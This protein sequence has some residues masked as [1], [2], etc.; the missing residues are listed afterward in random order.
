MHKTVCGVS[1]MANMKEVDLFDPVKDWLEERGYLVYPEVCYGGARADIVATNHPVVTVVE[2][3]TSLSL[4]VIAQAVRWRGT[5]NYVY[6][7]VP[8][9]QKGFDRYVL[10]LLRREGVGLLTV[11]VNRWYSDILCRHDSYCIPILN[12][13][14]ATKLRGVLS[15]HHLK[16]DIKGGNA[17]GGYLTPYKGTIIGVQKFLKENKG[18]R[19][20]DEILKHC[21]THYSTPKPSLSKSLRDFEHE[22][23]EASVIGRK[24][25][26]RYK[27]GSVNIGNI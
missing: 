16:M 1:N 12:R 4:D 17:G 6:V 27:D 19:T 3:K 7:G 5:A 18:W 25:H 26:F 23:C 9:P 14:P 13:K 22:W 11:D 15:E 8:K 21:N 2:L 10:N 24:L 20:M